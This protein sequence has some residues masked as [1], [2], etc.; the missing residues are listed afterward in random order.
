[1]GKQDK[2]HRKKVEMRNQ[3]LKSEQETFQK[4]FKESMKTQIE[5]MKKKDALTSGSTQN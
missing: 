5:E 3:K 2:E 1:M 4:L